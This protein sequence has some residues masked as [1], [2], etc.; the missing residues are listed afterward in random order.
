MNEVEVRWEEV[1]RKRGSNVRLR[2]GAVQISEQ[3]RGK[4]KE[5]GGRRKEGV[6][7]DGA[8]P[9]NLTLPTYH[10][11]TYCNLHTFLL[12]FL[13]LIL[14]AV[15]RQPT[16]KSTTQAASTGLGYEVDS[17]AT[18]RSTTATH[19]LL[20]PLI[21]PFSFAVR[22]LLGC[23]QPQCRIPR[24]KKSWTGG[25]GNGSSRL[26]A[27]LI[28]VSPPPLGT[29]CDTTVA[30][31][32]PLDSSRGAKAQVPLGASPAVSSPSAR[33]G[34]LFPHQSSRSKRSRSPVPSLTYTSKPQ[35]D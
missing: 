35:D 1:E 23:S 7:Q 18:V 25:K 8:N 17:A 28:S 2:E 20:P 30:S 27:Y 14:P 16:W 15:C 24:G 10:L 33:A 3:A 22:S 31:T 19:F 21:H 29:I 6:T 9:H 26:R 32:S 13:T 5:E 34:Q 12:T 4:C 11:P